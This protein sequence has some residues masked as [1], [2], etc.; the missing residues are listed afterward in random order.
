MRWWREHLQGL[1]DRVDLPSDRPRGD[2]FQ[3]GWRNVRLPETTAQAATDLS[4]RNGVT[5]FMVTL[6]AWA[7][8][9]VAFPMEMAGPREMAV[10]S[11]EDPLKAA[12]TR[13]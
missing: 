9:M 4:R 2:A 3:F 13:S 5:L 8:A 10:A 11:Q 7:L 1:A 6:A 12:L